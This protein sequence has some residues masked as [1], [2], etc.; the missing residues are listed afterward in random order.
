MPLFKWIDSNLCFISASSY[1]NEIHSTS[2]FAFVSFQ[3]TR[4]LNETP[5]QF[6][7]EIFLSLSLS[8]FF[9]WRKKK[10]ENNTNGNFIIIIVQICLLPLSH[11]MDVLIWRCDFHSSIDLHIH[12]CFLS[13]SALALV[14]YHHYPTVISQLLQKKLAHFRLNWN[15]YEC[16]IRKS[17]QSLPVIARRI[18]FTCYA[19]FTSI[20]I[21]ASAQGHFPYFWYEWECF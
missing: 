4:N 21:R 12:I 1:L 6:L 18:H 15:N 2:S 20:C 13:A 11:S 8:L 7:D 9:S 3:F 16:K 10:N 5:L 19:F 14:I 17:F